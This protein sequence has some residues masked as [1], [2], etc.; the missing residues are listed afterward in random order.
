[1]VGAITVEDGAEDHGEAAVAEAEGF[2]GA[3]SLEEAAV[4]AAEAPD[5]V[6]NMNPKEFINQLQHDAIVKAIG[7]AES[8][9]RGE[10]RVFIS[11]KKPDDAVIAAQ[12]IFDHL[13]MHKAPERNGVLLFVAPKARKFAVIGD[14]AVHEQCGDAFWKE[15]TA[16][17][18]EYFKK[19]DFT[20]GLL[21]GIRRAGKLLAEHFPHRPG[22]KSHLPDDIAHD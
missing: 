15:V 12:K 21:H 8:K 20:E 7:E 16:E 6:G 22:D 1:M 11:H 3:A 4:L 17:M 2:P 13:G 5:Q 14:K 9:M 18:S 19:G 10:I